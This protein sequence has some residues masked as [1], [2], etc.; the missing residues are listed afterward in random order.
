[1]DLLESR[2][3]QLPAPGFTAVSPAHQIA[4]STEDDI[5]SL[6]VQQRKRI[7]CPGGGVG[8]E[9]IAAAAVLLRHLFPRLRPRQG[10]GE[11][12]EMERPTATRGIPARSTGLVG[13]GLWGLGPEVK[14][15]EMQKKKA[16]C[17]S[18]VGCTKP[19]AVC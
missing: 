19:D 16:I 12:T 7:P 2:D 11:L 6:G 14:P 5:L 9:P 8:A 1:M 10:L 3:L 17:S 15:R 13:L 4:A 18:I